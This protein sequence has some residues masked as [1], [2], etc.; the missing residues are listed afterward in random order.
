M[1][2]RGECRESVLYALS[3]YGNGKIQ[4]KALS[5]WL[6]LECKGFGGFDYL[7]FG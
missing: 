6:I 5:D 1:N 4:D 7:R 3:T 2:E